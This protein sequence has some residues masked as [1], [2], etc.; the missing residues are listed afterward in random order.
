MFMADVEDGR[1]WFVANTKPL[2]RFTERNTVRALVDGKE[3]YSAMVEALDTLTGP[4]HFLYLAAFLVHPDFPLIPERSG[5]HFWE[6]L[7]RLD[8]AGVKTAI[9]LAALNTNG[10]L[11]RFGPKKNIMVGI[12][13]VNYVA[14]QQSHQ[15]FMI[16]HGEEGVVA[17]CGGIDLSDN[18]V[19][20]P[21]H[22]NPDLWHDVHARLEGPAIRDLH[23]TFTQRFNQLSSRGP[24][25]DST[26]PTIVGHGSQYV[27]VTRTYPVMLSL[28][29]DSARPKPFPFATTERERGTLNA[30]RRA[31]QRAQR[32]IYIEDQYL[33]PYG[34]PYPY[35]AKEDSTGILGDLLGALKRIDYLV[36]VIAKRADHAAAETHFRRARIIRTLRKAFPEK[37]HVFYM[38][39]SS[40]SQ[41]ARLSVRAMDP[42]AAAKQ[43]ML[44]AAGEELARPQPLS[45]EVASGPA[46]LLSELRRGHGPGAGSVAQLE[47]LQAQVVAALQADQAQG[48]HAAGVRA[49][50]AGATQE[51]AIYVHSKV[52]IV[53]DV[54]VKIGSANCNRRSYMCDTEADLHIIDGAVADGASAFAREFRVRLW[55]ELLGLDERSRGVLEDPLQAHQFW[56]SPPPGAKVRYFDEMKGHYSWKQDTYT[57]ELTDKDLS[58]GGQLFWDLFVDP[59]G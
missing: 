3:T 22:E 26:P 20:G 46:Q 39:T 6:I 17:F 54:Y 7:E 24:V 47:Q 15:K 48:A 10:I 52:L 34:G 9:L 55:A 28:G 8:G 33:T 25:L 29:Q 27:Q 53:D 35:D 42:E 58:K 40:P 41:A 31:L 44:R 14:W 57:K 30:I 43:D 56:K 59:T 32:Y 2:P 36:I 4:Q 19:T 51:R 23:Y 1:N 37:V 38:A 13:Y 11:G 49:T 50:A 5:T 18:R 12:D 45:P 16:I 21:D